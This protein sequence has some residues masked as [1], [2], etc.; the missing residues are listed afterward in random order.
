MKIVFEIL[1]NKDKIME[2]YCEAIVEKHRKQIES[3]GFEIVKTDKNR[4]K[5]GK[6]KNHDLSYPFMIK[7]KDCGEYYYAFCVEYY[8]QEKR[9]VNYGM[10]F[11]KQ[12]SILNIKDT[13]LNRI[14]KFLELKESW[15]LNY[16][17]KWCYSLST[18]IAEL[19]SKLQ[20]FLDSNKIKALNEKLKE[21]QA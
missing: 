10:K 12:D 19:E 3:K 15:W 4:N 9:Y 6:W 7:P 17:K 5:L 20:E 8:M 14:Q 1:K 11:F 21:Y 16:D 2:S 18:S 13:L